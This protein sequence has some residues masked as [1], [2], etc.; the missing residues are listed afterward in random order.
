MATDYTVQIAGKERY[1]YGVRCSRD[2]HRVACHVDICSYDAGEPSLKRSEGVPSSEFSAGGTP[3]SF[4][5]S[6]EGRKQGGAVKQLASVGLAILMVTFGA[7]QAW[8]HGGGGMG[9]ITEGDLCSREKGQGVVHFSA[10]QHA[11]AEAASQ[12]AQLKELKNADLKRYVDALKEEFQSFC[13][14]IPNTGKVTLTFD[15]ISDTLRTIPVGVRVVEAAD[16]G[17]SGTVLNIPQRVYP[18]GVV[19]AEAEFAKAGKYKAIVEVQERPERS[20]PGAVVEAENHSHDGTEAVS[21]RHVSTK[22]EEAYHAYDPSFSFPF[23]VGIKKAPKGG[24]GASIV[25]NPAIIVTTIA[26]MAI[27]TVLY[28]RRKKK[29][30]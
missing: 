19:R 6:I 18:S 4:S 8:A 22:E 12:L 10:Y 21:Q 13:R 15:L 14:D 17:E 16:T 26:G 11:N 25:S 27:G 5:G 9:G 29:A 30:A 28:V 1:N 23:T 20:H 24:G 3:S 7:S 2:E